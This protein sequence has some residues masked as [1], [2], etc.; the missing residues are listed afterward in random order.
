MK[1]RLI[2]DDILRQ[3]G[4]VK[5]HRLGFLFPVDVDGK[6]RSRRLEIEIVRIVILLILTCGVGKGAVLDSGLMRV[7]VEHCR[8]EHWRS[9]CLLNDS[10]MVT[11]ISMCR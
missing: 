11:D 8:E 7:V 9:D 3:R 10:G 2:A 4:K 1:W 6:E 5:C